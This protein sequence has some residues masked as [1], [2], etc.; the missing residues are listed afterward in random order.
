MPDLI[1]LG[2]D[3]A[4]A[5]LTLARPEVMNA[6]NRAMRAE[7]LEA[8]A[9][10]AA[11]D[12]VSA[13]ILTGA[14]D[15]AFCAGQDLNEAKDFSA[16]EAEAW[17]EEWRTLYTVLRTFPKPLIS[18]LN[19]VAAGSAFQA[20]LMTDVRVAHAGVRLGQPEVKSGIASIT[21][22]WI[23]NAMFGLSRTTEMALS[24]RLIMADEAFGAGIVHHLVAQ[25]QVMPKSL[26]IAAEM[27]ALPKGAFGLTKRWLVEMTQPGFDAA[28]EAARRYHR[29]AYESGEPQRESAGFV[30]KKKS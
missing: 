7:I 11:D 4:T 17:I 27:G 25:D 13:L 3:G 29:E 2:R 30:A 20:C 15:R 12:G 5:I 28:F 14:G 10:F 24:G 16:D 22:P 18:A 26:E 9:G 21:G 6:W 23:M 19:G 8:M 1:Q